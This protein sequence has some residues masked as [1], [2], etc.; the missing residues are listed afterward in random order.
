LHLVEAQVVT[1]GE[2][3]L[4]LALGTLLLATAASAQASVKLKLMPGTRGL[5][6][7]GKGGV[8]GNPTAP[9]AGQLGASSALVDLNAD[10]FDDLVVGA[11]ALPLVPGNGVLDEAGHVYVRF[12]GGGF[13]LPGDGGNFSFASFLAGQAVDLTGEP[14][15]RAGASVA[16]AGDVNGD[17]VQDVIIGTPGRTLGGR[18]AAGGAYIVFGRADFATLATTVTLS[19]LASGAAQRAVFV[20]GARSLSA[21]GT[22]VGGAVDVN[23]DGRDDVLLGAP[24]DSTNGHSQNGTATVL[25]GQVGF[26]ALTTIDLATQGAGQVTVVHGS[27]ELQLLGFS[28]AGIGR[29]D[30]VLPMTNNVTS[31]FLGD[32]V[33]IGAPG[34]SVG[35]KF[36]AGAVYMLRGTAGGTPAAS[37]TSADF[38]NGAFKAGVV[39]SGKATGDQAGFSV[40]SAGDVVFDGQGFDDFFITA[41]FSDGIGRPDSGSVYVIAGNYLGFNPQGFDL[42]L[43]GSG[44]PSIIAI[45]IQGAATNDGSLGVL[46]ANAGDW[47]GDGLPDLLL[48]FPNATVV[49]GANVFVAAGRARILNGAVVLFASGTVDL[50]NTGAGFE[51]LQLQGEL[52]GTHV[53]TGIAS[54]DFNGD[55]QRDA[56]IGAD[57]APSDPMPGDGTGLVNQRTGRAHVVYG[58][59]IRVDGITPAASHFGGPTVTLAAQNVPANAQVLVDGVAAEITALVAGD[60]GSITFAPPKPLVAGN[61]A[62]ISLNTVLGDV[63]YKNVLQYA[64]LSVASGPSPSSGFPGLTVSF[65]GAGFSTIDDTLVT[66]RQGGLHFPASV[67][68][69]N[70]IAGTMSVMLPAGPGGSTPLDVVV[71]N[72]NGAATQVGMLSYLPLVVGAV[73]PAEGLQTSGVFVAGTSPYEGQPS[74]PVT[75]TVT[76]SGSPVPPDLVLEFGTAAKGYRQATITGISG[77]TVSALLPAFLLGPQTVVDVRATGGGNVG[78]NTG[79]FTYLKSD[80][81]EAAEYATAGYGATPPRT[82]MAGEFTSNGK[83]LLQMTNW[84]SQV[85]VGIL[86]IGIGLSNPPI[87]IKGGLFPINVGLPYFSFLFPFAGIS[88]LPIAMQLPVLDPAAHGLPMHLHVITKELQGGQVRFGFSNLLTATIDS[89]P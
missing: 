40:A 7:Q 51:L 71:T 37:Y 13:G 34:T 35:T 45:H 60:V 22:S 49:N 25:Y 24:L 70:G 58:P 4:G 41:P 42:G 20:Q 55:G 57:R 82:L 6:A 64:T 66:I 18:T 83:V 59:V 50:S 9:I 28:V 79:A 84:P 77:N 61:T 67:Q 56:S 16:A 65:T 76:S 72:S 43:V 52:S 48:G 3:F 2:R 36:F 46:A 68:A 86:F 1:T 10:G 81:Q 19:S 11:P 5:E 74:I 23:S 27:A 17:G 39:Y 80:F 73:V 31:L 89:A 14:G 12:G 53:G 62:D 75:V 30:P 88:G 33:A 29:F 8:A 32:D 87:A 47:N 63:T 69:V 26:P 85:Q 54:G 15:D 44:N 38:G 21:C 78:V